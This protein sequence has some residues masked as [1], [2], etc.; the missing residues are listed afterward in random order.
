M[1]WRRPVRK[2]NG[3]RKQFLQWAVPAKQRRDFGLED[4]IECT[5]GARLGAYALEPREYVLTSGGE[6]RF[7]KGLADAL[8]SQARAHPTKEI[9]FDRQV[10][11]STPQLA[12]LE[13]ARKDAVA[14]GDFDAENDE[15]A[16]NR[17][18]AFIV[19][20]QG[21]PEFRKRLLK[22]YNNRCAISG[23]DCPDAL[24]AAH[25]RPYK[26]RHT[27]SIRN[28]IL[29][30]SDIHTLFDLGKMR[31]SSGYKVSVCDDLLSTVYKQF[32]NKQVD[33]PRDKGLWPVIS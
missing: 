30:R 24:E 8:E 16:R 21:Q 12:A 18:A 22:A 10:S 33:L 2:K 28:G 23:C 26:G 4:G 13:Q 14:Q 9:V 5:I 17:V 6:F 27:N 20:R 15:D 32:H 1:E 3:V 11:G 29:L 25:I 19:R 7:P 31:I